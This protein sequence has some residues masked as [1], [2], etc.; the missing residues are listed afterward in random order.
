M[1]NNTIGKTYDNLIKQINS[2]TLLQIPVLCSEQRR[3]S[4]REKNW[5][6]LVILDSLIIF[7][8]L[9]YYKAKDI[10]DYMKM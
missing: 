6:G 4:E 2:E 9:I 5:H 8:L 10:R 7:F 1:H 3:K